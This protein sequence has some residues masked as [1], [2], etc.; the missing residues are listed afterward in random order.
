VCVGNQEDT[1]GGFGIEYIIQICIA[2]KNYMALDPD[3]MLKTGEGQT[4][5]HLAML[6]PFIHRC[7]TINRNGVD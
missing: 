1:D 3:G 6:L 4:K 2:L 5:S 7:L